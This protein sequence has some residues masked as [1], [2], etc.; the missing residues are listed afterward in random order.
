MN[1]FQIVFLREQSQVK[2]IIITALTSCELIS[3]CI[4]T[5]A[6]TSFGNVVIWLNRLWIDFKLYFYVSNHKKTGKFIKRDTV[7]NW[8]QIVFLREQS[9]AYILL[10]SCKCCCELISNCIFTWAITSSDC[11]LCR[12]R[13]LWIDFKL[14]FYVSNHKGSLSNLFQGYVVNWFQIVFLR[15]QSQVH[16]LAALAAF[17]CELISNCIFTWAITSNVRCID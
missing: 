11:C 1:W 16:I 9:Q 13:W 10:V 8:F 3:N 5:W 17:S 15:E 12:S 7:V 6:I 2:L 4:F 14:Y